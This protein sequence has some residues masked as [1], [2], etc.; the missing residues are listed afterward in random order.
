M[1][2]PP[3]GEQERLD[4]AIREQGRVDAAIKEGRRL[5]D[6][7]FKIAA[8]PAKDDYQHYRVNLTEWWRFNNSHWT[9][10]T[11]TGRAKYVL[12]TIDEALK[13]INI[14]I[15]KGVTERHE[16]KR[17]LNSEVMPR[18]YNIPITFSNKVPITVAN[19]T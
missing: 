4:A 11:Q 1:A 14:G 10:S 2:G 3:C 17:S 7:L 12:K 13:S 16:R 18:G 9:D 8:L 6:W 19:M 15:D 5:T